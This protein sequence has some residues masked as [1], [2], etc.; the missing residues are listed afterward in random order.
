MTPT[1]LSVAT[2]LSFGLI[3]AEPEIPLT[4]TNRP[5]IPTTI[6]PIIPA[7]DREITRLEA[8]VQANRQR[9]LELSKLRGF[10]QAAGGDVKKV[11]QSIHQFLI[12]SAPAVQR[13][14]QLKAQRQAIKL[15]QPQSYTALNTFNPPRTNSVHSPQSSQLTATNAK[16]KLQIQLTP[17]K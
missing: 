1:I 14:A 11:D 12:S 3:A 9:H 5:A 2:F 15:N 17:A 10:T 4:S 7:L 13:L 6:T 16:P 8:V